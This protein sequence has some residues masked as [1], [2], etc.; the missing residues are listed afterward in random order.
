MYSVRYYHGD[1][2]KKKKRRQCGVGC[3]ENENAFQ[4]IGFRSGARIIRKI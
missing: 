1:S 3:T 4:T 2:G